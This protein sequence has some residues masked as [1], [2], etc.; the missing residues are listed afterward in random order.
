M[1]RRLIVLFFAVLS[2]SGCAGA[3]P[4][5]LSAS[6]P[7]VDRVRDYSFVRSLQFDEQSR[8]LA[9]HDD[10]LFI[11]RPTESLLL[12]IEYRRGNLVDQKELVDFRPALAV[13]AGHRV[14]LL[15]QYS[16]QDKA[17][18]AR[19]SRLAMYDLEDKN[20]SYAFLAEP[21]SPTDLTYVASREAIFAID[22]Y[23][24]TVVMLP[25]NV[26]AFD[27]FSVNLIERHFVYEIR[28]LSIEYG[29]HNVLLISDGNSNKITG[30]NIDSFRPVLDFYNLTR[31]SVSSLTIMETQGLE[32]RRYVFGIDGSERD[33]VLL[34]FDL[35]QMEDGIVSFNDRRVLRGNR[36][37]IDQ[38][39]Q[40]T[41]D[42]GIAESPGWAL[43]PHDDKD[44]I[45]IDF[46]G[47][48]QISTFYPDWNSLSSQAILYESDPIELPGSADRITGNGQGC[49][50]AG[51]TDRGQVHVY[52]LRN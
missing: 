46:Q 51:N 21:F 18:F 34:V 50:A 26:I 2:L 28:P 23:T 31:G 39:Q 4:V 6:G 42:L 37:F 20:L 12:V 1:N 3:P 43:L 16:P 32:A 10:Y 36:R 44:R 13:S 15:E 30:Y 48:S 22:A 49:I 25:L 29:G 7:G 24:D 14:Y 33:P 45:L 8:L 17:S 19:Q 47:S 9:F 5:M 41:F 11:Y 52:C 27:G 35:D 40:N 38:A